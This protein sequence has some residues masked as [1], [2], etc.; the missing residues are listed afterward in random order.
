MPISSHIMG[1][2]L[3]FQTAHNCYLPFI[4][5]AAKIAAIRFPYMESGRMPS[6]AKF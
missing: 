6:F 4:P 5:I 2:S 1:G 3:I